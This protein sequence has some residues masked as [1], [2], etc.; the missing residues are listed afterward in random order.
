[1]PLTKE[2]LE[3]RVARNGDCW[4]WQR[5][6]GYM[7]H[8]IHYEAG[9]WTYAHRISFQLYQ[10]NIAPGLVMARAGAVR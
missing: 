7:G 1:M 3:A 2:G 5:N 8:G 10:G 9:T 4:E 6:R